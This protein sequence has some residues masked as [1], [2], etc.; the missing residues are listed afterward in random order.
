ML[1]KIV[2]SK[3][4]PF[5]PII[6]CSIICYILILGGNNMDL[7]KLY[8]NIVALVV[9]LI[10]VAGSIFVAVY[11]FKKEDMNDSEK[12]IFYHGSCKNLN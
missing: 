11:T 10:G 5:L 12:K 3:Y 6:F 1:N 7:S 9:A 2:K 4:Y 8:V